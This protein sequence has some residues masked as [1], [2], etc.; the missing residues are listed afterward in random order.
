MAASEL[1]EFL[2]DVRRLSDKRAVKI[3]AKLDLTSSEN[4]KIKRRRAGILAGIPLLENIVLTQAEHSEVS[5]WYHFAILSLAE[6]VDFCSKPAWISQRLNITESQAED[7]VAKLLKFGMLVQTTEG[8]CVASGRS[9]A[10]TDGI[11]SK[12]IRSAHH[13]NFAL[14]ANALEHVPID[15][16]DFRSVTVAID[17][18]NLPQAKELIAEFRDRLSNFLEEGEKQEVYKLCIQLFPLTTG[19]FN[20]SH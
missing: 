17:P 2:R 15:Y 12:S 14:A 10:T 7:A 9:Y 5:E 11:P 20:R 8:Q 13:K 1:S 3:I 16:R 6:T 18:A 19:F 4:E